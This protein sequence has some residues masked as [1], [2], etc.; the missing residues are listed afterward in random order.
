MCWA[1]H[2]GLAHLRA[3]ALLAGERQVAETD[4]RRAALGTGVHHLDRDRLRV[5]WAAG[6]QGIIT[7]SCCMHDRIIVVFVVCTC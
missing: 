2:V 7:Y 3:G 1:M 4:L 5:C 6:L